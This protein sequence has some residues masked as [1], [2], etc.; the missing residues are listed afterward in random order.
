MQS[1]VSTGVFRLVNVSN[2]VSLYI[3]NEVIW[4]LRSGFR[5]VVEKH[6]HRLL[7]HPR[8]EYAEG[9]IKMAF[10]CYWPAEFRHFL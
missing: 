10:T 6:D 2:S 5:L 7:L 4:S 3:R 8:R 9:L 1:G